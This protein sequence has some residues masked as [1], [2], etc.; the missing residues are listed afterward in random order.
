MSLKRSDFSR[1]AGDLAGQSLCA[2]ADAD[3]GRAGAFVHELDGLR[4]DF[5]RQKLDAASLSALVGAAEGAGFDAWRKSFFGGE[6]VNA[7]EGRPALHMAW[8]ARK[9]DGYAA[10]G[11]SV[12]R[13]VADERAR[14]AA[15]AEEIRS[16]KR[17]GATG[18]PIRHILHLGIG[19]S[20]LGPRLIHEALKAYRD[21]QFTLRFA[22]N[23]DPAELND[24]LE[25]LDPETALVIAV[26]K[27][28]TTQE[29]MANAAHAKAWLAQHLQSEEAVTHHLA[30][31]TAAPDKAVEFGVSRDLIFGFQ[32]WVGGRFSLWSSV[33]LSLEIALEAGAMDALREGARAMDAY[34]RDAP[35]SDNL[36]LLKAL[37]DL[38][39]LAGLDYPTRC[40]APYSTRLKLLPN[41]LQQLEMESNGKSVTPEGEANPFPRAV[42]WGAEGANAQHAFFQQLHQGPQGAPV[43]F[44]AVKES[45]EARPGMH[46]AL[47][48]NC[49]AQAEALMRGR[50]AED[51]AED[52]RAAGLSDA[53]A[54]RLAPH[55][56]CP[57]NRPSTTIVLDRLDPHRLGLLL[58]LYEHKTAAEGALTGVNSFDQFGVELGKT[59]AGRTLKALESGETGEVD[60]VSAA[61]IDHL[62]R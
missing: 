7:T 38:F 6:A 44:I 20:D 40:I 60:A 25:G 56:A 10:L 49:A 51:A 23:I 61:M 11:E 26:S 14:M 22:A 55:R 9:E 2:L 32:D 18:R 58:A 21:P 43:D 54:A 27:S 4:A 46:A 42:V 30:A 53:E 45:P 12:A 8:R 36:P 62:R 29:T 19:G 37:I 16:A 13:A 48:A 59:L 57:G 3:P 41:F 39:N 33:A 28:F 52:M 31:V 24:A 35:A 17:A 1:L 15:L 47:L 34:F 50:T 5:S